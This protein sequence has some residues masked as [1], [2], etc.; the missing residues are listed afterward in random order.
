MDS[1]RSMTVTH[2]YA[3][4]A[5][6]AVLLSDLHHLQLH[7]QRHG[8]YIS[9]GSQQELDV[10]LGGGTTAQVVVLVLQDTH[11]SQSQA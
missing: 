10:L 1:C 6:H 7:V 9:D 2:L 8:L 4:D 5:E 11:D 3:M